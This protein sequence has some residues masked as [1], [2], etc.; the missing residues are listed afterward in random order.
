MTNT[1]LYVVR[2][3]SITVFVMRSRSCIHDVV[4]WPR[5]NMGDR[6]DGCSL[7]LAKEGSLLVKCTEYNSGSRRDIGAL[8]GLSFFIAWPKSAL[9]WIDR[10]SM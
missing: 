5:P 2:H 7:V 1:K 8:L 10:Y 3:S 6:L 9:T 4:V